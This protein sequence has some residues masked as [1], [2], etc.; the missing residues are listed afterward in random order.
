[1]EALSEAKEIVDDSQ[2]VICILGSNWHEGIVGLIAGKLNVEF[3]KPVLVATDSNG[4]IKGSAR[5]I[6]GFNVTD[7]LEKCQKYLERFGGHE[8]AGGFTVKNGE[9]DKFKQCITKFA[10]KEIS[11]DM[12]IPILNIDLFLS[13]NDVSLELVNILKQ[14]E[15]FG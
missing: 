2:N 4:E 13:S 5:S 9:W 11:K 8:M 10:N 6:K 3:N 1:G 7:A 12:L 15:P 14:L